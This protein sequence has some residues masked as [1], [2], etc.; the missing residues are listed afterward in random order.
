MASGTARDRSN[1]IKAIVQDRYGS[2]D[3]LQLTETDRPVVKHGE[4]MVR[5]QA[6]AVRVNDC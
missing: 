5:V 3:V 6:A 2:P 4:V 1:T